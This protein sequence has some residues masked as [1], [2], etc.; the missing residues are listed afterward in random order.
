MDEPLVAFDFD[1][2]LTVRDSYTAFLRRRAGAPG[3][4]FAGLRLAPALLAYPVTRDRGALKAAATRVFLRG[5]RLDALAAETERFAAETADTLLRPDAVACWEGWAGKARRVI[6]TASP[7]IIVLPF[8]TRLGADTLIGTRL[9]V[10]EDARVTGGFEGAN[11]RGAE[12]V[13]RLKAAFGEEVRVLAAYGDTTGDREMLAFAET[14]H[15]GMFTA[16]PSNPSPPSPDGGVRRSR[17][18][19]AR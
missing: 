7:E 12:K 8:A 5:V 10:D 17:E 13:A 6:V 11:C 1:G 16:T 9:A 15:M 4:A 2:T 19:A 3:Y 14:G 18:G